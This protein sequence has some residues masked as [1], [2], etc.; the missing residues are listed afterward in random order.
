MCLAYKCQPVS[1]KSANCSLKHAAVVKEPQ[2]DNSCQVFVSK[3]TII[4]TNLEADFFV[5][6]EVNRY[7]VISIL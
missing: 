5:A 2:E 4:N 6:L 1:F 7:R 3:A